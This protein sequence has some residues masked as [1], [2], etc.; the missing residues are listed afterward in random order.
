MFQDMKLYKIEAELVSTA[1][2]G[3]VESCAFAHPFAAAIGGRYK[4]LVIWDM[5]GVFQSGSSTRISTLLF[6]ASRN[7]K[8][9]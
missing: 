7:H 4:G 2:T 6:F 8:I 1:P 5:V 9:E 3:N